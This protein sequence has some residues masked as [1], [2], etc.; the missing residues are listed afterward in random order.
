M[1][2]MGGGAE[3]KDDSDPMHPVRR[4]QDAPHCAARSKR[5]GEP[6]QGP[7]VRGSRVCRM[8]GAGGGGPTGRA[9]GAWRHGGRTQ[10]VTQTRALVAMLHRLTRETDDALN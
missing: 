1:S 2:P 10:E 6:C 3:L 4:L 8:H 5:T 9:N 7:A